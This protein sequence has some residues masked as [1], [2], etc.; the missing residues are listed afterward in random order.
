[1][2]ACGFYLFLAL[3]YGLWHV[4]AGVVLHSVRALLSA[5]GIHAVVLAPR[6]LLLNKFG[7]EIAQYCSG[8]ESI[9]LFAGLYTLIALTDFRRFNRKRLLLSL[10]I[11]LLLLFGVNILRVFILILCGYYINPHIAFSL[12]HTYAGMLLFVVYSAIFWKLSYNW[13]SNSNLLN[14]S[15]L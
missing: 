1:V 7:I 13:M 3:V 11:G 6:T 5:V 4:L 15:K 2:L 12:F 8:I 14:A 10:P 9:A